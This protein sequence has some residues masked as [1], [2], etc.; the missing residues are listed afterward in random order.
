MFESVVFERH[1]STTLIF[2]FLHVAGYQLFLCCV[3]GIKNVESTKP[4]FQLLSLS[5]Y[6]IPLACLLLN[7]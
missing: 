6:S 7:Y 4:Y 2:V 1:Y 3:L 5:L